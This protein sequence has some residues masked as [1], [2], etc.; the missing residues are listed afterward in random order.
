MEGFLNALYEYVQERGI[1]P[2]LETREYRR[3]AYHL[4][5]EWAA[6]RSTLTAEQGERL[7]AL[8]AQERKAGRLE[9]QAVFRSALSMGVGLGWL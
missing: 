4:E 8:L 5:A 7:E 1:A 3:T 6:F 9:E 2:Y